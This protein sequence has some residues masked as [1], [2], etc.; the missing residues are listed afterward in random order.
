M[1]KLPHL[2]ALERL[3][4]AAGVLRRIDTAPGMSLTMH[5][6]SPETGLRRMCVL[7]APVTGTGFPKNYLKPTNQQQQPKNNK[8]T[9]FWLQH[10]TLLQLE[11]GAEHCAW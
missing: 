10:V 5:G 1:S 9:Y 3:P 11:S 7:L 6:P 8:K 4:A 2:E